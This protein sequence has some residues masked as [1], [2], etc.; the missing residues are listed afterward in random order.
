MSDVLEKVKAKEA[1]RLNCKKCGM[2]FATRSEMGRHV[3]DVHND[4]VRKPK[5][6]TIPFELVEE[7]QYLSKGS[8]VE[9]NCKGTLTEKGLELSEIKY[10]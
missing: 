4:K 6:F 5:P 8:F 3:Y 7:F 1:A 2:N 9:V 10:V